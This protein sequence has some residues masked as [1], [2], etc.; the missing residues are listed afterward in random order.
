[1]FYEVPVDTNGTR[2]GFTAMQSAVRPTDDRR[3]YHNATRTN[4][5]ELRGSILPL[6]ARDTSLRLTA[7]FGISD[8]S[9]TDDGGTYYKDRI[10]TVSLAADY[11]LKDHL[12]GWN[13][14]SAIVRQG[15]N[16]AGSSRQEDMTSVYG[17]SGDFT[18]VNLS[19]IRLQKLTDIWSIKL[20]S[21]AQFASNTLLLSQQYFLGS[22]GFGSGFYAGDN[23]VSGTVELRYDQETD[24]ALLRGYQIYGFLDGGQVWNAAGGR[25]SLAS[26]G[27]GTRFFMTEQLQAGVAIGVPIHSSFD[28]DAK[29]FRILFSVLNAFK[30]CPESP[31]LLQCS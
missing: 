12:E 23:G 26:V 24:Y 28:T 13:Y 5:Y 2:I 16:V 25:A 3:Y 11:K 6:Q 14:F 27:A 4:G 7:A 18:T 21:S 22:A 31:H 17:A 9:E 30:V 8:I 15:V 20:A 10:R 19:Y 29:D 1:L